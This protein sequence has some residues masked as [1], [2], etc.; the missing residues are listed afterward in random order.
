MLPDGCMFPRMTTAYLACA[1]FTLLSAGISLTYSYLAVRDAVNVNSA[2]VA[3]YTLARSTALT[4]L[5]VIPLLGERSHWL[6]AAA[7]TMIVVQAADALIG[8]GISDRV[9]TYGPAGL[10]VVNAALLASYVAG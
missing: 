5:A 4:A 3:R 7:T 1:L 8:V 9:K 2:T 6:I 10:A